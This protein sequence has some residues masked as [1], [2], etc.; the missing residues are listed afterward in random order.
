MKERHP[1]VPKTGRNM[2]SF[3]SNL[4]N[5]L[6]ETKPHLKL[7]TYRSSKDYTLLCTTHG[8][9]FD[10]TNE[11]G[12]GCAEC[13]KEG[14]AR[15]FANRDPSIAVQGNEKRKATMVE[16]YGV[17]Y[18]SMR[19]DVKEILADRPHFD[20]WSSC[21]EDRIHLKEDKLWYQDRI[22]NHKWIIADFEEYF[23]VK[24][25][26]IKGSLMRM[27]LQTKRHGQSKIER[28]ICSY[29]ESLGFKVEY[30]V[31]TLIGRKELDIYVPD[32]KLAIE[33]NGVFYH[34]EDH[35][36]NK[37]YHSEKLDDCILAGIRL[38]QFWD[39]D[40]I[41]NKQ[42]ILN[43][44]AS[45]LGKSPYKYHA[46]KCEIHTID[47]QQFSQFLDMHHIQGGCNAGIRLGLFSEGRLVGVMGFRSKPSNVKTHPE[48][49]VEIVRFATDNVVGGFSKLLS[50]FIRAYRCTY[51]YSFGDL[52][53]VDPI[54]NV[55]LNNGFFSKYKTSPDYMYAGPSTK[56][57]RSHKFNY[58]K[59][60]FE[61]MGF[62]IKG[63]TESELAIE[64]GLHKC[65]DSGMVCY[66]K[67]I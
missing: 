32:K 26:A 67:H 43:K 47:Q 48:G 65:W 23:N 39:D 55:Y 29:I 16:K 63:K 21:P 58:R 64:A 18:N 59:S 20:A 37:N 40:Y 12:Y 25:D 38:L 60:C 31:R 46:R 13:T 35:K 27:G 44:I 42:V 41:R 1:A 9:T 66:V 14:R 19:E 6:G 22:D 30:N 56:W 7:V 62:D 24:P 10:T 34:H 45:V 5:K 8:I 53:V 3:A 49:A 4:E 52:E 11:L 28:D 50:H 61:R 36:T 17:P 33:V 54:N 2:S 57:A 51:I 15:H